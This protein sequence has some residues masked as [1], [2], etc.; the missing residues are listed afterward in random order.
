MNRTL[1]QERQY[2]RAY[3]SE[4][5]RAAALSLPLSARLHNMQGSCASNGKRRF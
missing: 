4:E 5:E 2:A 1:A 3:A